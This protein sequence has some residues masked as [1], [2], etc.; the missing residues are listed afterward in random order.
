MWTTVF[1]LRRQSS[2]N[3]HVHSGFTDYTPGLV[4]LD[5]HIYFFL[6]TLW[7]FD[8]FIIEDAVNCESFSYSSCVCYLDEALTIFKAKCIHEW[9]SFQQS[10]SVSRSV[11]YWQSLLKAE[12]GFCS[13]SDSQGSKP[14][15]VPVISTPSLPLSLLSGAEASASNKRNVGS[16]SCHLLLISSKMQT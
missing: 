10:T 5:G 8:V 15:N 1:H 14:V 4:L 2:S 12:S 13:L 9:R 16:I 7:K 3:Q 11:A 6:L